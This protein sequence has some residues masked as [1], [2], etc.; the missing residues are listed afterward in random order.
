MKL[1]NRNLKTDARYTCIYNN[2]NLWLVE[3]LE[4][5]AYGLFY[6]GPRQP[7]WV[8]GTASVPCKFKDLPEPALI[9]KLTEDEIINHIVLENI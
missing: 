3:V 1:I 8:D 9:F 2:R 4:N 7:N 6:S 5:T